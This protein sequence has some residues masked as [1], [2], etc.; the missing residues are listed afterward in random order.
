MSL[1]HK[2][3]DKARQVGANI[4]SRNA[5]ERPGVFPPD[6]G[7]AEIIRFVVFTSIFTCLTAYIQTGSVLGRTGTSR[8]C[9]VY[10]IPCDRARLRLIY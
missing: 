3:F 7:S 2:A 1:A 6:T 9:R 8:G 5:T 10:D 4:G